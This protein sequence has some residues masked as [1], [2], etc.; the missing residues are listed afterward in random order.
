MYPRLHVWWYLMISKFVY[1]D[2]ILRWPAIWK[3]TVECL[4]F[5]VYQLCGH[6]IF[7][8]NAFYMTILHATNIQTLWIQSVLFRKIWYT[9]CFRNQCFF[10]L[11]FDV[12]TNTYYSVICNKII[13]KNHEQLRV[14]T[15]IC[16]WFIRIQAL[17]CNHNCLCDF[18]PLGCTLTVVWRL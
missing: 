12:Q 6:Q 14:C 7:L 4:I 2:K 8:M 11:I 18:S 17:F 3:R 5:T 16:V 10:H 1:I 15:C 9:K 13:N